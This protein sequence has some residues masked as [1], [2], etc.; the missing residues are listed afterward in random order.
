MIF[1]LSQSTKTKPDWR[2][3]FNARGMLDMSSFH[4]HLYSTLLI[5]GFTC[6]TNI[7][8]IYY[9]SLFS[10]SFCPIQS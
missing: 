4:R 2:W 5:L 10:Y 3:I 8:I 7:K 9:C 1:I 6:T